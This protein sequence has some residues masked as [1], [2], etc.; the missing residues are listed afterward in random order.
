MLAERLPAVLPRLAREESLEVT[1]V[2]SVAGLLP[3]GKR[4]IDVA[5]TALRTTRPRCSLWSAAA[6]ASRGPE[7][8]CWPTGVCSSSSFPTT[9]QASVSLVWALFGLIPFPSTDCLRCVQHV[10]SVGYGYRVA[11]EEA[12]PADVEKLFAPMSTAPES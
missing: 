8:C 3:P 4:P 10:L 2:H 11:V 1:A 5:P 6:R 12:D 7:R 9:L